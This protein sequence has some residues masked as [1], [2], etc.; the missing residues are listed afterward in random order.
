M[1]K[2][3]GTMA[4][5]FLACAA[6][7]EEKPFLA[8]NED[9]SH[10]YNDY[11][12][13]N[14]EGFRKYLDDVCRGPV[15]HF[16]I[17][18]NAQRSIFDS[19][20]M[21]SPWSN[22][23]KPLEADGGWT[24]AVNLK[25]LA[26]R[27]MDPGKMWIDACRAKGIVPWT[28]V[29]MNDNHCPD[30]LES[31]F[32]SSFWLRHREY[33]RDQKCIWDRGLNYSLKPVRDYFLAFVRE[34]I[35]RYDVEGIEL[36][37]MRFPGLLA[38]GRERADAHYLT[39]FMREVRRFTDDASKR[40]GRK[41]KIGVRVPVS[42]EAQRGYGM[43]ADIWAKEG[44]VDLIVL[45]NFYH[46]VDFNIPY[47]AYAANIRALNPSVNVVPCIESG[48]TIDQRVRR[49]IEPC[50]CRG[51]AEALR[52]EGAKDFYLFNLYEH[53]PWSRTWNEVLSNGFSEKY[54]SSGLR[55]YP[56]THH[57]AA[58]GT[59]DGL[60]L[61]MPLDGTKT[62]EIRIGTPPKSGDVSALVALDAP[63]DGAFLPTV[64]LNG[65]PAARQTAA[66]VGDWVVGTKANAQYLPE[67]QRRTK[68]E[69]AR[70]GY[71]YDFPLSALRSGV[72]RLEMGPA[73]GS[74]ALQALALEVDPR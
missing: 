22:R 68:H 35:D 60:V 26:D 23:L 10:F 12:Q 53:A 73:A 50:E 57:D 32:H 65:V 9:D 55:R 3:M 38:I 16:F 1:N 54:V 67:D 6:G 39:E 24:W 49:Q 47:R 25:K 29:R 19:K 2:W 48:V 33:W 51:W 34:V 30:E 74:S 70:V 20:T 64:K 52:A 46:S 15:T 69:H 59:P 13:M 8:Y 40:R 71:R 62:F 36:D 72:N 5:A 41:M 63:V 11:S 61:P 17:C 4:A 18:V 7:A 21:D 56:L 43:D 44:L 31:D 45:C 27:G 58:G 28:S 37:W 66:P 42:L 14:P